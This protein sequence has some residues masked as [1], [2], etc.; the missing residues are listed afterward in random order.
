MKT[1]QT[2]LP[3]YDRLAKQCYERAHHAGNGIV[4]ILTPRYRLPSMQW[5]AEADDPGWIDDIQLV[6]IDGS[7]T[8][9]DNTMVQNQLD[10]V[11]M[12][13]IG[14]SSYDVFNSVNYYQLT[15]QKTTAAGVAYAYTDS[16]SVIKNKVIWINYSLTLTS[17]TA[18]K[19][20]I[21]DN[22]GAD[23]S[24]V[25]TMTA[26]VH[27]VKLT[28]SATDA[29]ASIR[30]R[31]LD[32]ELS[33][34]GVSLAW[35]DTAYPGLIADL[36]DEYFIYDGYTL[37]QLLPIGLY[38]LKL[39]TVNGY[40]YY[41][42]WFRSDCIYRNLISEWTNINYDTFI[43]ANT[44][45]TSAIEVDGGET[46]GVAKSDV[47]DV[48]QGEP[49][50]VIFFTTLTSGQAPGIYLIE[51]AV[52]ASNDETI[53]AG[54]NEIILTPTLTGEVQLVIYNTLI[55]NYSITEILVNRTYSSKY[56]TLTFTNTCDLGELLYHDGFT[57]T[58]WFESESMENSYPL[59]EE[60]QTNNYNK[61][62]RTFARQ[63]KKYVARTK[64]MPDFMVDVFNRM[65]LH[66]SIEL[67]DL[68]GD[69]HTVYNLEV[70]HEWLFDDKYYAKI[71]LTFDY[72]ETVVSS[73]CCV[74][75]E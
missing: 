27:T 19:L 6:D 33:N 37:G 10:V 67:I 41:S 59:Q 68:V 26:G 35:F 49:V 45:I 44:K 11:G 62:F 20:V 30:I 16:F 5:N 70:E 2:T 3:V 40:I 57:Q 24:P 75:I 56:L 63:V 58:L 13:N 23:I 32:T 12:A 29:A 28:V 22:A 1:I 71:D 36:T 18:P 21:V 53:V 60:G 38:Y 4:P 14:N 55:S 25:H 46:S 50:T 66:N 42:D 65:K 7:E 74:A 47:F 69:V 52:V 72:D 34:I 9:L 61:F 64:M 54:L 48:V 39:T 17:G 73:G 15:A 43:A 31:N 51:G 8:D